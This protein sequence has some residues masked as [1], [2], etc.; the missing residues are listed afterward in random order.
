M[1]MDIFIWI[2][3]NVTQQKLSQ[4]SWT[5]ISMT[6]SSANPNPIQQNL[7]KQCDVMMPT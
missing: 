1:L 7:Q 5:V 3:L 4:T 6:M 2:M